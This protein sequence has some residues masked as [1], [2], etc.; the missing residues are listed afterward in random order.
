[1]LDA[2]L[3]REPTAQQK[4]QHAH[5]TWASHCPLCA[6]LD[7]AVFR[8]TDP[9]NHLRLIDPKD[10]TMDKLV[11]LLPYVFYAAG[12]VCFLVGTLIVMW[13]SW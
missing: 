2:A 5:H 13:R 8:Y 3:D 12:S 1:M 4:L 7:G 11:D 9:D 6:P 10:T